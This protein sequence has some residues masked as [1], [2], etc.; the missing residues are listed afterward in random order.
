MDKNML[1]RN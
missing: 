1:D